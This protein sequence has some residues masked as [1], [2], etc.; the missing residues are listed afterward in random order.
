MKA[1]ILLS[2]PA[3]FKF[4]LSPPLNNF[5]TYFLVEI[6]DSFS[7]LYNSAIPRGIRTALY[8]FLGKSLHYSI[9]DLVPISENLLL[10]SIAFLIPWRILSQALEFHSKHQPALLSTSFKYDHPSRNRYTHHDKN[11]DWWEGY[12]GPLLTK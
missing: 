8:Q 9:W 6:W 1:Y 7:S 12:V 4:L 5:S 3:V 2:L 10:F 11:N